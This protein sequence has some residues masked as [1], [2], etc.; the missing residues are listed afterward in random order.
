MTRHL[1]VLVTALV[2][3]AGYALCA[4]WFP[5]FLTTRVI[6]NL[7]TDNAFL[8]I[9]AVGMTF[10]IISGGIDLS[11]GS[12]IGF[13]TVA[14]A[15]A[16]ERGG[17]PAPAAFLLVLVLS[18]L[19]G[20]AQGAMIVVFEMP[21]FIVTLAGM[22]LAR[23]AAFLLSTDSIPVSDPL[24]SSIAEMGMALPGGGRLTVVAATMLAVM[25]AGGAL[26]HLT[27]FGTITYALGGNRQSTE[28]M[29]IRVG[30]NTVAIYTLSGV[31]SGLA[32][33]VFSLY[34]SSG[35]S[36]AATGVELD[37]IAA[38][39]IGG[40][41]LTGGQGL[42]VGTFLGVMVGGLIQTYITFDGELSS[43]WAKIATGL[44]LFAF[45]ALQ[46]ATLS[47]AERRARRPRPSAPR[48]QAKTGPAPAPDLA[49]D[50]AR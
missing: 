37:T 31:L 22:F 49:A 47:L 4:A 29:G 14:L 6:A 11:V 16:V 45:I 18:A 41:L 1:P 2:F 38:V 25:A 35:N 46:A 21:P 33:I 8:G 40:T 42:M 23:G 44:L 26:L 39:V 50:A 10:V 43:W 27:R 19:F 17:V 32:G 15:L 13:T 30:R 9:A 12:V 7:L 24:Y 48:P 36:L 28:L 20:A 3:A 5:A 34:T